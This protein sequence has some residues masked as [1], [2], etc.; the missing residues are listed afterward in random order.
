M[1]AVRLFNLQPEKQL[2][3]IIKRA[4]RE[5]RDLY[6]QQGKFKAMCELI[7]LD[8]R[9]KSFP[10]D[11]P[12]HS[13]DNVFKIVL[14]SFPTFSQGLRLIEATH[15]GFIYTD[16]FKALTRDFL[17]ITE[18]E[19]RIKYTL[20]NYIYAITTKDNITLE[21][22]Y[23]N[24][25]KHG[26]R[27]HRTDGPAFIGYEDGEIRLQEWWLNGKVS[28]EDGPAIIRYFE[29]KSI[30]TEEWFFKGNHHRIGGPA[31]TQFYRPG[32]LKYKIW[33]KDGKMHN[34]N[35][36]ASIEYY[37]NGNVE[38]I[39]WYKD[40]K[41]HNE[42]GPAIQSYRISPPGTQFLYYET[43]YIDGQR[44][45]DDGPAHI[46]Y[47]RDGITPKDRDWYKN[48]KLHNTSGPARI[49]ESFSYFVN[50]SEMDEEDFY[51]EY[52]GENN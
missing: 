42:N 20:G 30:R 10:G 33:Y 44:H 7:K 22:W 48:G 45:R 38:A 25:K 26:M 19:N 14:S 6:C 39:E 49:E 13:S 21:E 43:W 18:K 24:S 17:K 2:Y 15:P 27:R 32:V 37:D 50:G 36:P 4:S 1:N 12:V 46:V 3:E 28:R 35:G 47:R 11:I 40:G 16:E 52:L 8:E 9:V 5:E 41:K 51:D 34:S 29:D 23:I 31:D